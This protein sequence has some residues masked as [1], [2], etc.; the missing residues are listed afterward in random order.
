MKIGNRE[1]QESGKTYVCGILNV[2]PDSF[3]TAENGWSRIRRCS[4]WKK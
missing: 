2:T 1:F 3:P 4:M